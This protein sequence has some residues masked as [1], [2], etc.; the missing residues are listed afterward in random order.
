MSI[1]STGSSE[2]GVGDISADVRV[3]GK[4]GDVYVDLHRT[5]R[6]DFLYFGEERLVRCD[7]EVRVQWMH[8]ELVDGVDYLRGRIGTLDGDDCGV[9]RLDTLGPV[10]VRQQ[11][12]VPATSSR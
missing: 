2:T 12:E 3:S 4:K 7:P 1:A 8:T 11:P 5:Q 9:L 6:M 10:Y